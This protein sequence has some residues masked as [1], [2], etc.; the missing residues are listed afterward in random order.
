MGDIASAHAGE[1]ETLLAAHCVFLVDALLFEGWRLRRRFQNGTA[2]ESA[3]C[4]CVLLL[5]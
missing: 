4:S 5:L 3:A 2:G 1:G